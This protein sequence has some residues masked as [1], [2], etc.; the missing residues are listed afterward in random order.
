MTVD[1]DHAGLRAVA[2]AL[3]TAAADLDGA[4][5]SLP[6]STGTGDAAPLLASVL[7]TFSGTVAHLA[8]EAHLIGERVDECEDAY[9]A[10]DGTVSSRL[11]SMFEEPAP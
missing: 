6:A 5:A 4:C 10:T 7:T 1:V 2:S 11:S 9:A 3:R 8:Y